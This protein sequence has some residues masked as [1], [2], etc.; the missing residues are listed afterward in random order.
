MP[1]RI[2]VGEVE[3]QPRV[4]RWCDTRGRPRQD[5]RGLFE[6]AWLG[7][8]KAAGVPDSWLHTSGSFAP[9]GSE[10]WEAEGDLEGC[11]A[12]GL[13]IV[14]QCLQGLTDDGHPDPDASARLRATVDLMGRLGAKVACGFV[15]SEFRDSIKSFIPDQRRLVQDGSKAIQDA[16]D[17]VAGEMPYEEVLADPE[18]YARCREAVKRLWREQFKRVHGSEDG[19]AVY[20]RLHEE[21]E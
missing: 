4:T 2:P 10:A 3:V 17:A 20:A 21:S 7:K 14:G 5:L 6:T 9:F 11:F 16:W 18:L 19:E 8:F 15:V 1:C 12:D 13:Y